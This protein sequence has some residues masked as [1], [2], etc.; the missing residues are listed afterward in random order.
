MGIGDFKINVYGGPG[1][2]IEGFGLYGGSRM[3]VNG[4][5]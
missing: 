1:M 4:L 2:G 5:T 3:C